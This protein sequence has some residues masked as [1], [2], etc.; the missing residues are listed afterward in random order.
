M[1]FLQF[2][3][4][5]GVVY[6]VT[7]IIS[8]S[9]FPIFKWLQKFGDIPRRKVELD[10]KINII[11]RFEIFIGDLFGCFLCVS[12]WVGCLGSYLLFD[13]AAFVEFQSWTWFTSGLFYSFIVWF[14]HLLEGKL[15]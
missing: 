7:S 5:I 2:I 11:D 10:L 8:E 9:S 15:N 12:V 3:L 1:E 13:C 6:Q 4:T 14:I